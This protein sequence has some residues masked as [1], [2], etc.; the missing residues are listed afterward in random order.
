[1]KTTKEILLR[2][3]L[4]SNKIEWIDDEMEAV[5][6]TDFFKKHIDMDIEESMSLFHRK[7][8]YLN[9]YCEPW[10]LRNYP[11][12]VGGKETMKFY[13]IPEAIRLL[14]TRNPK[15]WEEIKQWHIDFEHIHPFGDGNGRVGR[16]LM[17]RQIWDNDIEIPIMFREWENFK[18]NRQE[19]YQWF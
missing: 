6:C 17:L 18:E 1:M 14:F 16:F 3:F 12:Y 10:V 4:I 11:V 13:E 7:L 5:A 2:F 19:Y 9:N 8:N 15:T